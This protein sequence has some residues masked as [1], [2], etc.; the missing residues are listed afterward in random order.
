MYNE[1]VIKADTLILK[2]GDIMNTVNSTQKQEPQISIAVKKAI[3]ILEGHWVISSALFVFGTTLVHFLISCNY[4]GQAEYYNISHVWITPDVSF[5]IYSILKSSI[6]F[7]CIYLC[8]YII[9]ILI[10]KRKE[11]PLIRAIYVV[12]ALLTSSVFIVIF[13]IISTEPSIKELIIILSEPISIIVVLFAT[14]LF[15]IMGIIMGIFEAIE[16]A[17]SKNKHKSGSGLI[18]KFLTKVFDFRNKY[19]L[20][21]LIIIASCTIIIQSVL[22]GYSGAH[23]AQARTEYTTTTHYVVLAQTNT[24][25]LCSPILYRDDTTLVFDCNDQIIISSENVVTKY[26]NYTY[27]KTHGYD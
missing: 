27:V 1:Y 10:A 18:D 8:N 14:M 3:E 9:Y 15:N 21:F 6:P 16:N 25:Y 13:F 12:I 17:K 19:P 20:I 22:I 2:K 4:Y 24:Q 11:H 26:H 5:T 7:S 23:R